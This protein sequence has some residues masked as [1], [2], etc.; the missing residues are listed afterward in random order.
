MTKCKCYL[1]NLVHGYVCTTWRVLLWFHPLRNLCSC[2]FAWTVRKQI[3]I[4]LTLHFSV[5]LLRSRM[6][7][8]MHHIYSMLNVNT[9]VNVEILLTVFFCPFASPDVFQICRTSP[10]WELWQSFLDWSLCQRRRKLGAGWTNRSIP[11][12]AWSMV[13]LV[14]LLVYL[15][16]LSIK[17]ILKWKVI[18]VAPRC[19]VPCEMTLI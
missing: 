5:I 10:E 3:L 9:Y 17:L 6:Q 2:V 15:I 18:S 4:N 11:D 8:L 14:C 19:I 1:Q 7:H 16:G 12:L 13:A